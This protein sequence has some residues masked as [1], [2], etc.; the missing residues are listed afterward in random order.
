MDGE[1]LRHYPSKSWRSGR[2]HRNGRR[3]PHHVSERANCSYRRG[4]E[5]QSGGD[6]IEVSALG[7]YKKG[8]AEIVSEQPR[9]I[10]AEPGAG[11]TSE[12]NAY[13]HDDDYE[14]EIVQDNMDVDATHCLQDAG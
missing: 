5:A 1:G 9:Q 14:F 12:G 8:K 10:C 6:Q 4:K 13:D 3:Q 11:R 2:L 7:E